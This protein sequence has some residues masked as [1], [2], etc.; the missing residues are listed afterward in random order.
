M[1]CFFVLG[2][3]LYLHNVF[4]W[5]SFSCFVFTGILNSVAQCLFKKY[6]TYVPSYC[7]Y[8]LLKITIVGVVDLLFIVFY[9]YFYL[10]FWFVTDNYSF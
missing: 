1:F 3:L 8:Y 2:F 6:I 4:M 5:K 7:F 10:F 9:F